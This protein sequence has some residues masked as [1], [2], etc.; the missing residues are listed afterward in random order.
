MKEVIFA[1]TNKG[2]FTSA[3]RVL[4]K[5]NI[6]II[7]ADIELPESQSSLETIAT[8]KAIY[9]YKQLKKPVFAMDAGFFIDSLNGFPMMYA[10]PVLETIGIEGLLKLTENKKREC[11][12]KEI[13]C[14]IDSLENEPVLFTRVVKG[15][16]SHKPQGKMN[17][18][19]WS[20]LALVFIPENETRTMAAMDEITYSRFRQKVEENSHFEQFGKYYS[21]LISG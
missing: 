18:N 7:Q 16:L 8:H 13:V 15:T 19:H 12:F 6:N 3:K 17:D 4:D 21:Q 14:F 11:E 1:T 9:A 20:E 5:Y 10:K 2:K